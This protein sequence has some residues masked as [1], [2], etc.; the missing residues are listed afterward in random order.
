MASSQTMPLAPDKNP[1]GELQ[2]SHQ[3]H[4]QGF[5][6]VDRFPNARNFPGIECGSLTGNFV[7]GILPDL[8]V[9]E[10]RDDDDD[11]D[12]YCPVCQLPL[13]NEKSRQEQTQQQHFTSSSQVIC[14][15]CWPLVGVI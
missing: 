8:T 10:E 9:R 7:E 12:V 3:E 15:D 11:D 13:Q 1:E 6:A 2:K 4:Q 14:Q 5:E